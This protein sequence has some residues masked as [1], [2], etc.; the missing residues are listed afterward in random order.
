MNSR[1]RHAAIAL[2]Q[3]PPSLANAAL[4]GINIV[5]GILDLEQHKYTSDPSQKR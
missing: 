5:K 3:A 1:M 4:F 2:R